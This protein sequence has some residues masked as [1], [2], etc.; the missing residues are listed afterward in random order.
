MQ[1]VILTGHLLGFCQGAGWQLPKAEARDKLWETSGVLWG[2]NL[3]MNVTANG[4]GRIAGYRVL[5]FY[6]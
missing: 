3:A 2:G 4:A 5:A 1:L 6:P